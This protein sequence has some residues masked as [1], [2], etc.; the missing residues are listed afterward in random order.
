[1]ARLLI[2]ES[3]GT[4]PVT[5]EDGARLRGLIEQYWSEEDTLVL[6]FAGLRIASVSF[7]DESLGML[8]TKH[9]VEQL[10]QR[11]KVENIDSQDRRLLN[12]I[13]LSRAK[14]RQ[15]S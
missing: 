4:N 5:R 11:V 14:D 15:A 8:A 10:A 6:D 12:S 7:F 13:V 1:M 2:S 3:V 9:P